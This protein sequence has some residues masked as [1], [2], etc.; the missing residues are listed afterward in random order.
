MHFTNDMLLVSGR[1]VSFVNEGNAQSSSN[2]R[3]FEEQHLNSD[4]QSVGYPVH[5]HSLLRGGGGGG[6]GG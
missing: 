5:E 2:V 4:Q 6:G 1:F 3:S